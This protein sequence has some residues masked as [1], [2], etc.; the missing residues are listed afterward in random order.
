MGQPIGEPTGAPTVQPTSEPT[1]FPTLVDAEV[2]VLAVSQR[3]LNPD[4]TAAIFENEVYLTPFRKTVATIIGGIRPG[5]VAVT[6]I[7]DLKDDG[8]SRRRLAFD[9]PLGV[10][11]DYDVTAIVQEIGAAN[12][13]SAIQ[14]IE[15]KL[16]N[17]A[18]GTGDGT[19][20]TTLVNEA[21]SA[22]VSAVITAFSAATVSQPD[23]V[24]VTE[25]NTDMPTSQ[26]TA[27]PTTLPVDDG[28]NFHD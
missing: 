21:T 14:L 25:L 6:S 2:V 7:T 13:T 11:V 24:I 20:I 23:A 1:S 27:G 3:L 8:L 10:I 5:D 16:D 28:D 4:I 12:L 22:G 18:S 19:F 9:D 26:P 17:S 15:S